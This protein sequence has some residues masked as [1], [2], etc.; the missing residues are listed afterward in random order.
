M[1]MQVL[2]LPTPEF[3]TRS[4]FGPADDNPAIP[5]LPTWNMSKLP[6]TVFLVTPLTDSMFLRHFIPFA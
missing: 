2:N 5:F 6:E 3:W 1:T 4:S